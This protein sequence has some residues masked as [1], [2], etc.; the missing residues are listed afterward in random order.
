[1]QVSSPETENTLHSLA[2]L[3]LNVLILLFDEIAVHVP[4]SAVIALSQTH[5]SLRGKLPAHLRQSFDEMLASRITRN[6]VNGFRNLLL[7]TRAVISGSTALHFI[8]RETHWNPGDFD[9][10]AP[11]GTGYT[12]VHWLMDNEGYRI[13]SDGSKSF[14]FHPHSVPVPAE[15][16]NCDWITDLGDFPA[17]HR[18]SRSPRMRYESTDSDIYRVY[19]LCSTND[20]FIDVVE[21]SKPSFLPPITKFHSTLVMNYITPDCVVVLYP[22]LTFKREGILQFR[23]ENTLESYDNPN[24]Q[25]MARTVARG[26]KQDYVDKYKSRGYTLFSRP[27]DLQRPCGAA[28]PA[29]V[30]TVSTQ[31]DQWALH[32]Q[33]EDL[34]S[35]SHI[36]RSLPQDPVVTAISPT[37]SDEPLIQAGRIMPITSPSGAISA[38]GSEPHHASWPSSPTPLLPLTILAAADH[39]CVVQRGYFRPRL[40]P[41]KDRDRQGAIAAYAAILIVPY[42]VARDSEDIIQINP[43]HL[44]YHKRCQAISSVVFVHMDET[45][46]KRS[47]INIDCFQVLAL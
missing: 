39:R 18:S 40:S 31:A 34:S 35:Y 43:T 4:I 13:V 42:K 8:L 7:K 37:I 14:L 36:A 3:S 20:T 25:P 46:L 17:A 22:K 27:A 6:N 47:L 12:I 9:I 33:I 1:M 45:F 30:R 2:S 10:Y 23:D 38:Y 24:H 5:S 21:S 16:H 15:N 41:T 11:F 29:I 44:N 32:I 19:K 26:T 28:C